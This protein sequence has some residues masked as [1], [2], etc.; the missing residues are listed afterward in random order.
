MA[1][2]TTLE[3]APATT[4]PAAVTVPR[5][6]DA[7]QRLSDEIRGVP[8]SALLTINVDI[9]SAV[10]TALGALPEIRALRA[11]IVSELPTL[12]IARFDKIE[13][14]TLAVAHAHS[15]YLVASAPVESVAALSEVAAK[16]RE[17]LFSDATALARRGLLDAQ[18]LKELK[19]PNGYRN[20]AFD[21]LALAAMLRENWARISAK[22]AV[23]L[24]ELD[25]AE[26]VADRLL[27]ALGEREQGPSSVAVSSE[28]RQRAFTLFVTAYDQARRAV[29][30]LRWEERDIDS[31]APSLYAGRGSARRRQ[32]DLEAPTS[33]PAA[34]T[35]APAVGTPATYASPAV[36][37]VAPGLP[38]S[39]PFVQA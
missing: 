33:T 4:T 24:T 1:I 20:L 13:D 30:H 31:I 39:D 35:Q 12:D 18:R 29:S 6:R 36:P 5:F 19:G 7:Y 37:A 11:R 26:T 8:D 17:L 21:L 27:T 14:Y 22:T 3:S 16:S 23:D 2:D 32:S 10:T 25:Q 34:Q 38:G 15:L 9:P 28:M